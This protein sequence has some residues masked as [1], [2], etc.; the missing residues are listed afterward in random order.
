MPI[1]SHI[2]NAPTQQSG[3]GWITSAKRPASSLDAR[4]PFSSEATLEAPQR[5]TGGGTMPYVLLVLVTLFALDVSPARADPIATFPVMD[6]TMFM[7]PNVV[8]DNI[9]FTFTGP[10]MDVRGIGGMACFAWCTGNPIPPGVD[11]N[12]TQIFISNFTKAV[13][14][15]VT[16][17]PSTEI[18][19]SSPTFFNDSGGLNPIAM[20]FVGSG[21]TFAE[22][23]MIMPTNG[24]WSLNFAPATDEHGNATTRF[25]NGTF[26]ASTPDPGTAVLMLVGSAG[27]W[28]TRRRTQSCDH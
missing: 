17:D 16:Y 6:A 14:G 1:A 23:Q 27:L 13:L 9:S 24:S 5:G 18:G 28:I 12:L 2:W 26:S 19:V 22:F 20:G 21:P 11:T 4:A 15:G 3:I 8:G 7:T 25:V 10:G